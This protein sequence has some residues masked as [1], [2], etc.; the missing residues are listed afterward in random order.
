[1]HDRQIFEVEV[2]GSVCVDSLQ[3]GPKHRYQTRVAT[4][5][6]ISINSLVFL[7]SWLEVSRFTAF[8][9]LM[10]GIHK[11]LMLGKPGNLWTFCNLSLVPVLWA[12]LQTVRAV[13]IDLETLES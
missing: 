4:F 5:W 13:F 12:Q 9:P 6:E 7:K 10:L 11:N 1:L 2:A 3:L 8:S